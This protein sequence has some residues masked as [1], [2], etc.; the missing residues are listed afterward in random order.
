MRIALYFIYMALLF[1][2]NVFLDVY[3]VHIFSV[4]F[5]TILVI[6]VLIPLILRFCV[7]IYFPRQVIGVYKGNSYGIT[8]Y[9]ENKSVFPIPRLK[10]LV[11][12]YD[13]SGMMVKHK[14]CVSCD[15][16][17]TA[18]FELKGSASKC[19]VVKYRLRSVSFFDYINLTRISRKLSDTAEA[20]ILPIAMGSS[21]FD[22]KNTSEAFTYTAK[23][24]E[25]MSDAVFS[26]LRDFANGDKLSDIHWKVSGRMGRYVVKRYQ[27]PEP[28]KEILFV[29]MPEC[30][31]IDS[32]YG[33]IAN[34]VNRYRL[35][36]FADTMHEVNISDWEG[37]VNLFRT[38]YR[39][40]KE[41]NFDCHLE[42]FLEKYDS[43]KCKVI[44]ISTAEGD[45]YHRKREVLEEFYEVMWDA[46][47]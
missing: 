21:F 5:I 28:K 33:K 4:L 11:E 30:Q 24:L 13:L 22:G 42:S 16:G 34:L 32:F 26:D 25:Q 8:I 3:V 18:K 29:D 45:E 38:L 36:Y 17:A 44:F 46:E 43:R 40:S 35:S 37:Y 47:K 39:A 6:S 31:D 20:V 12:E 14:I 7:K 19:S 41:D 27:Y 23:N 10:L 1:V 15:A 9:V 2:L